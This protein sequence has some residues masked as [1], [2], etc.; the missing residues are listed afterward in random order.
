MA[1]FGRQSLVEDG[2][3][4]VWTATRR[5][6]KGDVVVGDV[7]HARPSTAGLARIESVGPRTSL[8]FRADAFRTKELAANIDLVLVVYAARPTFNRWFVWKSLVAAHA[9]G[10]ES[11]VIQNK[12]DLDEDGE[13]AAFRESLERLG[14]TTL[15]VSAKADPGRTRSALT[16]TTRGRDG[17][18]VGQSGMGKSTLLNLLVPDAG[19]RTQ[20][21]SQRL[22]LGKQTTTASRRFALPLGGSIV[23]TPGFQ[24]FGL[25]HVPLDELALSLPEF[26]PAL[27]QCRFLDCRHLAEPDCAVRALVDRGAVAAD[28]YA[29]YR[30]LAE[31]RHP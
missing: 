22:D 12:T 11:V 23:D 2:A 17:L 19:A 25:A 7:V 3:G 28:R 13:A 15:A 18:L 20:E 26:R 24:E 21:F 16:A 29:F 4:N 5:G 1:T 8:L 9:A 31:A 30:S 6:K 27:G 14:V 10:I